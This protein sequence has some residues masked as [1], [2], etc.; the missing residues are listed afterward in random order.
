MSKS[1]K[2]SKASAKPSNAV[3][4]KPDIES[5]VIKRLAAIFAGLCILS[6]L[7]FDKTKEMGGVV[8]PIMSLL[9]IAVFAGYLYVDKKLTTRNIAILLMA[10]GFVLRLNYVIY[11]P[12]SESVR[13]RQHDLYSFGGDKGHSA[14]IEHFYNNGFTLPDFDPTTKAQFYHPPLH[15]LLAA[16]WMRILTTFGMSYSRAVGSIQFLTLFYSSCCMLVC[17]RIFSALRL[18]GAPLL[19]ALSIVAFHPTFIILAGSVNNDILALL[20]VL[21][22][23][24]TTIKWY[25]DPTT[26]NILFIALSIG[27]AMST[28]LSG[29]L[30]AVPIAV[31]FLMKLITEKKKVYDNILQYCIFGVVCLPL[32]LWFSIRNAVKFEVPLTYVQKLSEKSDQYIGDKSVYERLFDLTYHPLRNV[33]LNRIATGAEF[34][35][36]NPFVAIVKTSLFGEYNYADSVEAITPFCRILLILNIVM[37]VLSLAATVYFAIKKTKHTDTTEKVFVL[38]YQILLFCYFIK[39]CFDFPHNCSMDYRYIVPTMVLGAFFIGAAFDE[40]TVENKKNTGAVKA[41]SYIVYG[42][43]AAFCLFSTIV[44]IM[45]GS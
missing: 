45:L 41:V 26:K 5:K 38:F 28:K 32:G 12:L 18:K 1:S 27:L 22:S 20:F 35:E 2:A 42:A 29:A 36:Y 3:D 10:A 39:F 7:L 34:Y 17:E 15:H 24:Y 14:Y 37:I 25:E 8:F 9:T 40:F 11:T 31:V 6:T 33:F 44:Y 21:L 19:A 43:T 23:V 16:M 13:V 4:Q 30:V